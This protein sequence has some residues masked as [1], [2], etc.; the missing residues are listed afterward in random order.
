MWPYQNV[1][2]TQTKW[3]VENE[4]ENVTKDNWDNPETN[5]DWMNNIDLSQKL[6]KETQWTRKD[7]FMELKIALQVGN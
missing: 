2:Q 1:E 4:T 7:L 3:G 5:P 6:N